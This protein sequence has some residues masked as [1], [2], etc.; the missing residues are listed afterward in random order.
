M[1]HH[2]IINSGCSYTVNPIHHFQGIGGVIQYGGGMA[3][4]SIQSIRDQV[5]NAINNP[6][7]Y[8]TTYDISLKKK[9][10]INTTESES[11]VF[12]SIEL[13]QIGRINKRIPDKLIEE[14][15]KNC[16][17]RYRS[18]KLHKFAQEYT[19]H[20]IC[21]FGEDDIELS[22]HSSDFNKWHK[23][24]MIEHN[25]KSME[26]HM[27]EYLQSI[28]DMQSMLEEN[29]LTYFMFLMNNTF[30]GWYENKEGVLTHVY[31]NHKGYDLPNVKNTMN[32]GDINSEL[33]YLF[34]KINFENIK[35]YTNEKQNYGGIDEYCI[36]KL[37]KDAF[38]DFTN[39]VQHRNWPN[40]FGLHPHEKDMNKFYEAVVLPYVK[41]T[42]FYIKIMEKTLIN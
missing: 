30:E 6:N 39:S 36:D 35:F 26:D 1:K 4:F 31:N 32:L 42:N 27:V 11:K 3:A 41:E 24:S 7:T 9:L 18:I 8:L 20:Y 23:N 29:N 10:K 40:V 28:I 37:G 16:S 2:Y 22:N 13:T 15:L 25:K 5:C 38:Q 17:P 34:N 14:Y 12:Y 33:N 19:G 21:F